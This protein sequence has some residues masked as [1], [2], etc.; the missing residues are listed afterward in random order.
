MEV[1][2]RRFS[3]SLGW[4]VIVPFAS[5]IAL[6]SNESLGASLVNFHG[7]FVPSLKSKTGRTDVFSGCGIDV[8]AGE[9]PFVSGSVDIEEGSLLTE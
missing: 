7:D 4:I 8:S 1:E 3:S 9:L 6:L 5:T 2:R